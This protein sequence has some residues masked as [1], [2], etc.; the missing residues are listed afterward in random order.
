MRNA[1]ANAHARPTPWGLRGITYRTFLSV[2]S[3]GR[4]ARNCT[5]RNA[6][7]L[8]VSHYVTQRTEWCK[9]NTLGVKCMPDPLLEVL[10]GNHLPHGFKRGFSG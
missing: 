8:M 4:L 2:V 10:R 7:H 9:F 6:S 1:E 3:L 5:L